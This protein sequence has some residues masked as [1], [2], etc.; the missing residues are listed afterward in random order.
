ML[1]LQEH[2]NTPIFFSRAFG[3][4]YHLRDNL[5]LQDGWAGSVAHCV[6]LQRLLSHYSVSGPIQLD[7]HCKIMHRVSATSCQRYFYLSL[8][9]TTTLL[10]TCT[11]LSFL[12]TTGVVIC[13]EHSTVCKSLWKRAKLLNINFKKAATQA[14]S[15]DN[16]EKTQT[17]KLI[18][19]P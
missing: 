11:A 9:C 1:F 13:H 6:K 10:S 16:M 8:I 2:K 7:E 15:S 18:F 14:K 19:H 12:A 4:S 17:I 3:C 5:H